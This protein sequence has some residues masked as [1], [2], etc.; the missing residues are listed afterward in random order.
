MVQVTICCYHCGSDQVIKNGH[1]ENGKQ[2]YRCQ[3][4]GKQSRAPPLE[5]T[6]DPID[7]MNSRMKPLELDEL[8]SFGVKR[9]NKVWVWGAMGRETRQIVGGATGD[10]SAVTGRKLWESIPE[11]YRQGHCS[12][13]FWEPSTQVIPP[14]QHTAY[15]LRYGVQKLLDW[16]DR[17]DE[18]LESRNPFSCFRMAWVAEK[19]M[20]SDPH[21]MLWAKLS[22]VRKLYDCGLDA[23]GVREMFRV[24]DWF[25][26]LPEAEEDAFEAELDRMEEE[27]KM[28]YITS[29]ERRAEKRGSLI[30]LYTWIRASSIHRSLCPVPEVW[31]WI[32]SVSDCGRE[33]VIAWSS[34]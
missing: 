24:V 8:W 6:L 4:C 10:R 27:L 15:G 1:A 26:R 17:W 18:L 23:E 2:R 14:D 32:P 29:V 5:E 25:L 16:H 12:T 11:S 13:D 30:S 33:M 9:A 3:A 19:M 22:A 31:S 20:R 7:P 21:G 28:P 34:S